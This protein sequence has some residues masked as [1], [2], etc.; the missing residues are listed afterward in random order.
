MF[1]QGRKLGE[2]V[3]LKKTKLALKIKSVGDNHRN[4]PRVHSDNFV[5]YWKVHWKR[6]ERNWIDKY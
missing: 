4:S 1:T 2:N 5:R 6:Q 3:C